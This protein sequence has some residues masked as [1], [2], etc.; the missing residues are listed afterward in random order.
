MQH[1]VYSLGVCLLEIG[2]W[3]SFVAYSSDSAPVPRYGQ[4]YQNFTRWL[5][6]EKQMA[7]AA[8]GGVAVYPSTRTFWLKG[9]FVDLAHTRLPLVNGRLVRQRRNVMPDVSR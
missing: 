3:R 7:G 5:Q 9:Y 8:N 1:D 6:H 2:L 4:A